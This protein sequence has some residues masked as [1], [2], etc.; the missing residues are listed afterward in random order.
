MYD[1][2]TLTDK[3]PHAY[4]LGTERV[5]VGNAL[6][7]LKAMSGVNIYHST[8]NYAAGVLDGVQYWLNGQCDDTA[9][10]T[11]EDDPTRRTT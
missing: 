5:E 7:E 11:R 4:S 3:V 2:L 9:F 6:P 8:Y 1:K 10:D